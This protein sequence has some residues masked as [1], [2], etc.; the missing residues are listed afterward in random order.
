MPEART[1]PRIPV[2]DVRVEPEDIEAVAETLRSGWL[3]QGPRTEAFERQFA[4]HLGARHVV[5]VSSCT[6]A[7]HLACLAAG[8]GEGD[9]VIVP[10]TTFVATANSILYCGGTPVFADIV[11]PHDLNI[12]PA[13][14]ERRIGERTKAVLVVHFAGYPA[15][16]EPIAELCRERGVALIEDAA[17]APSAEAGGRKAGTFGL[18][19]CFSFFSNKVLSCGE[20]G[21]LATDDDEVAERVRLLHSHAMTASTIE[22]HRGRAT[23]YDVTDVGFNYRIDEPR[24]AFLSS[25]LKRLEADVQRRRELVLRYRE[26]LGPIEGIEIPWVDA[27]VARSSCYTM[28]V[29]VADPE[30]REPL[31]ARL[32]EEHGV[33]TTVY[34]AVHEL[35]V[36]R[37]ML[38]GTS[39]PRT[40]AVA[41]SLLS[42]P[43]YTHM[44]DGEQDHV[45]AALG[46]SL[47]S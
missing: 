34:P 25:R 4:E 3:T 41:R 42:I 15:A 2:F 14:V 39:L 28:A 13:E 44:S 17:Q 20:G 29:V 27:D 45:V 23:Q 32:R 18:A 9:E 43:L 47:G 24:A 19:G 1:E 8:V 33:Q 46:E 6:A 35:E 21:A 36:Y 22:R 40:E 31:R 11:G 5:G 26:L 12:D 38:P 16:I 10:A 7:L 37:R 30:R